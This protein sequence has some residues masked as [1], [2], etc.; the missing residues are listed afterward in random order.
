MA[1]DV[2]EERAVAEDT[3]E[4]RGWPRTSPSE[5]SG[6]GPAMEVDIEE[7]RQEAG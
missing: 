3:L 1:V 5:G 4:A 7:V 2:L 6:G